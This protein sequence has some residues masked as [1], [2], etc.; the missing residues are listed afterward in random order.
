MRKLRF[1]F[2]VFILTLMIPQMATTSSIADEPQRVDTSVPTARLPRVYDMDLGYEIYEMVDEDRYIEYI[3][4]FTEN[5]ERHIYKYADI[6]GSNNELSR[7]WLVDKMT[8]V[9][10]ERL[11]IEI[12][13]NYLSI[14]GRLPGYLPGEHPVFVISAH[15][16]TMPLCPG[17]NDNGAGIAAV[18]E[19]LGIMSQY[20]WPL[21]IYFI[22]F[23]VAEAQYDILTPPP[24]RLRGSEE[25]SIAFDDRAIEILAH[26]DVGAILRVAD[27]A[28]NDERVYLAYYDE[29][30]LVPYTQSQYWAELGK[31]M[32]NWYGY[33]FVQTIPARFFIEYYRADIRKFLERGYYNEILAFETG[34]AD[35]DAYQTA[36]DVWH[37]YDYSYR[38]GREVTALIGASMAYSMSKA[39]GEATRLTFQGVTYSGRSVRYFVPVTMATRLNITARWFGASATFLVYA[40][41]GAEIGSSI[42]ATTHPWNSTQIFSIPVTQK[43]LYRIEV[44]DTGEDSLGI[45]L[46][47]DYE[48]DANLNGVSDQ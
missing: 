18:L 15:Y 21:D 35:D 42:Q 34:L 11:E 27:H 2:V 20:E 4:E 12:L 25:V 47:I 14:V 3:R 45:E 1:I 7:Y 33:D 31:T 19:L 26:F 39:Y 8:E 22:A 41:S 10:N 23:N 37:R 38:I 9:S 30:G 17:A 43:G 46:E 24:G 40:P 5:G 16:D 36:N 13:G 28:P 6:P 44:W 48:V 29:G 32:S